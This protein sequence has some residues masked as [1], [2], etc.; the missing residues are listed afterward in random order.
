MDVSNRIRFLGRLWLAGVILLGMTA[1]SRADALYQVIDLGTG[2]ATVGTDASGNGT[3]TGSNGQTYLFDQTPGQSPANTPSLP[4]P[5]GA[6]V[7]DLMTYGNP[8]YAFSDSTLAAMNSQGLAVGFDN[9]GVAGHLS[10]TEVFATQL[11]PNGTWGPATPLWTGS[12]GMN[13][14]GG[15]GMGVLGISQTGQILGYGYSLYGGSSSLADAYTGSSSL[16]LYDSTTRAITSVSQL[17]G[18][19][20]SSSGAPWIIDG[21][22]AQIDAQG[23][24]LLDDVLDGY[25][26]ATHSLLLVPEGLP[27]ADPAAVPEPSTWAMFASVIGGWMVHRRL[28][29]R[30]R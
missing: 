13:G 5:V 10:N 30:A 15:D 22:Q 1:I 24:I 20:M 26:G 18:G 19:A 9:F 25:P 11:Q 3:V 23:R 8:N 7:G 29:A 2:A 21:P 14:Y 16:F 27:A 4:T 12:V 28:R 17:L 6:P